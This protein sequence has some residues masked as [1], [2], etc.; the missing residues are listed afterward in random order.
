MNMPKISDMNIKF[1]CAYCGGGNRSSD[2]IPMCHVCG[3]FV[4]P[5]C[6]EKGVCPGCLSK[7]TP[8]QRVLFN[9]KGKKKK[10]L[11]QIFQKVYGPKFII[12]K[13]RMPKFNKEELKEIPLSEL[14]Q[15]MRDILVENTHN[16]SLW[17]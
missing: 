7:L 3:E 2:F 12:S 6:I 8:D 17:K 1:H 9:K 14:F 10:I 4:C 5:K 11:T 15:K 16:P 13:L